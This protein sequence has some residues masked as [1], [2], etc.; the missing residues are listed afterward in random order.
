MDQIMYYLKTTYLNI[1]KYFSESDYEKLDNIVEY[2]LLFNN[3]TIPLKIELI[4]GLCLSLI[5][6]DYIINYKVDK[7]KKIRIDRLKIKIIKNNI[8]FN[9][10]FFTFGIIENEQL[11]FSSYYNNII[12]FDIFDNYIVLNHCNLTTSLY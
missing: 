4:N 9:Y 5:N 11:I 10:D 3:E 8:D 1:I 2:Y 6:D 12:I 7:T